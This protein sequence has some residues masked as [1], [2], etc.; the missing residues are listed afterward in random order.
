MKLYKLEKQPHSSSTINVQLQTEQCK[1]QKKLIFLKKYLLQSC[2]SYDISATDL[3]TAKERQ[4]T[5]KVVLKNKQTNNS[6]TC[7]AVTCMEFCQ[8]RPQK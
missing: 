7:I 1:G 4:N 5:V 8:M 2:Y 3:N 6:A